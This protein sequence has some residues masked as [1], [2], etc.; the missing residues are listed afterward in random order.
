MR[1]KVQRL[2]E[3]HELLRGWKCKAE[4][5][6]SVDKLELQK[7]QVTLR[8]DCVNHCSSSFSAGTDLWANFFVGFD[9]RV[10]GGYAPP[11]CG[12]LLAMVYGPPTKTTLL[13]ALL[14]GKVPGIKVPCYV[15]RRDIMPRYNESGFISDTSNGDGRF[16]G[17]LHSRSKGDGAVVDLVPAWRASDG[18]VRILLQPGNNKDGY[19]KVDQMLAQVEDAIDAEEKS[20]PG[21]ELLFCFDQ[22][23]NHTAF[24]SDA[25]RASTMLKG[26]E[27]SA[28]NPPAPSRPGW[29]VSGKTGEKNV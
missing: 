12:L 24:A 4:T 11:R 28:K 27:T 9:K 22:S 16:R 17:K 29:Y 2:H 19:W 15:L 1:T 13:N 10:K 25:L 8:L 20:F 5:V 21:C 3:N 6:F 18:G 26:D 23:C 14:C 7:G